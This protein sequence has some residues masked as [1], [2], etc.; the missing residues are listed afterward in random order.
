MAP[1]R[2]ERWPANGA[3]RGF[4][5]GA[6]GI[7]ALVAGAAHALDPDKALTQYIHERWEAGQGLPQNSVQAL[8]QARD[9]YLWV[10]TQEGLARFD[11]VR[12]EVFDTRNSPALSNNFIRALFE[13]RQGELWIGT[14]GGGLVHLS[15]RGM[16]AVTVAD[17]LPS[18]RVLAVCEAGKGALWVGTDAGLARLENGVVVRGAA[19]D[20]PTDLVRALLCTEDGALWVGTDAGLVRL[21]G[22]GLI[23]YTTATG[24]PN[25]HV[26][27]MLL[28]H[29]ELWVGTDGGLVRFA[30]F[31][32]HGSAPQTW[33]PRRRVTALYQD[34]HGSLWIGTNAG[35]FRLRG[36]A[37]S[38]LTSSDGLPDDNILSLLA[39]REGSLWVGTGSGG[40]NRLR[41]GKVTVFAAREGLGNDKV[42]TIYEDAQ[43][44]VWVGTDGGLS[45][46]EG[47]RITT[48]ST[49]EGLPSKKVTSV[50]ADGKG[51]LWVGTYGAG[52]GRV[53]NGVVRTISSRDGLSHDVITV[54]QG[55]RA[56]D[57]WVGTGSGLNRL[58]DGRITPFAGSDRLAD[59]AVMFI[60]EDRGGALWIGTYGGGLNRLQ[61]GQLAS[62]TKEDGLSSNMVIAAH[63]DA[64]GVLWFGTLGGGLNRYQGGVFTSC[65][66]KQ[67]LFDDNV[68]EIL[69]DDLGNFWI[70][71]HRGIYRVAKGELSAL[72]QSK[73]RS[74]SCAVYTVAE[75]MRSNECAG[76]SQPAGWKTRDGR[77][78]FATIQ[79]AVVIDPARPGKNPFPPPV[80]I[81]K[82]TVKG[83]P[84]KV[85][86]DLRLPPGSRNLE[87]HYTALSFVDASKVLFKYRLE[88]LDRD[89]VVAGTRRVAYYTNLHPGEYRFR[90]TACNNDA[91]WNEAG[92]AVEFTLEPYFYQTRWFY[93]LVVVAAAAGTWGGLE[94]RVRKMKRRE[95]ELLALIEER[96]RAV[97]RLDHLAH[98]DLL[99]GL[100]NRL[101]FY[102]GLTR[103]L[104]EERESGRRFAL[105]LINLDRFNEINDMMGHEVG[106]MVLRAV[107]RRLGAL[108]GEGDIVARM[109]SDEFTVLWRG[110][111]RDGDPGRFASR[112]LDELSAPLHLAGQEFRLL[113]SIGVAI[114]PAD[115][116]DVETLMRNA[117]FAMNRAKN[118]G[119]HTWQFI[120]AEVSATVSERIGLKRS[121]TEALTREEFTLH[122]QPQLQL[123]TGRVVAIEALV[124]WQRPG[125]GELLPGK[126]IELAEETAFIEP[127]GEWVL[128]TACAQGQAWRT[129]GFG[130][131]AVAVNLSARQFHQRELSGV[132]AR[133]LAVTGFDA[134]LL[135][136]E[137]TEST[138]MRDME[139]TAVILGELNELGVSIAVDDFGRGYSSLA[140]LKRFP[141]HALKIDQS[142]IRDVVRS[143]EDAAIV[144]AIV[145][146][147][148]ALNL[149]VVA[150][151][152]ETTEQLAFLRRAGCDEV[153]GFLIGRPGP[154]SELEPFLRG[155]RDVD[156]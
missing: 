62:F 148:H 76:G 115:G 5:C 12:F 33:V 94:V 50:Y 119:G 147:A 112:I 77:L 67:G 137:I 47:G 80:H 151:G 127:L 155:P 141:I 53:S 21:A 99:T 116:D 81:E 139:A 104:V 45:R 82:I 14:N 106:D 114:C 93:A 69:E 88:G 36:G 20:L 90:V 73:A 125:L 49:Q 100:P 86:T 70:G 1:T 111:D 60:H 150:E 124:R 87:I 43:G 46:M 9:G 107:A 103:A 58:R 128:K 129:A 96:D 75:G 140:Y 64:E 39:D 123:A 22:G 109:G 130:S 6:W 89:W 3:G 120:T 44:V 55:D 126:F 68:F 146:M 136:L 25:N 37:L 13:D 19:V 4:F 2:A 113:A 57:L 102:D 29:G 95:A 108:L 132:I 59:E 16:T 85:A 78:W 27:A 26:R 31:A 122:Y 143:P 72:A 28:S 133:A 110:L 74:V 145:S 32:S 121:L 40:L 117:D 153:Q 11:G 84:I 65:T 52:L 105:L 149:R 23:R 131:C 34:R 91:V 83:S 10:A 56:G 142:F 156:A 92:A 8:L 144:Q 24:L 51:T 135:V 30:G 66:T 101:S 35:L 41:D 42:R 154:P 38:A 63:E 17:G 71:C 61:D 7:L 48:L 54:I 18:N 152:V 97:A 79:G 98:H 134:R 118:E 15:E 138:A